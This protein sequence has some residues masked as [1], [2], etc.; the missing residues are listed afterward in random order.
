MTKSYKTTFRAK[1][2]L[3]YAGDIWPN[4]TNP[5]AT[6]YVSDSRNTTDWGKR[7]KLNPL[8]ALAEQV[9][10]HHHYYDQY[11]AQEFGSYTCLYCGKIHE[12]NFD[13]RPDLIQHKAQC[14]V[15]L[16][17]QYLERGNA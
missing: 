13:E 14:P 12:G 6:L 4:V 16:A 9:L 11:S 3:H 17:Q 2:Y 7:H 15:R 1:R 8:E 5:S 10:R